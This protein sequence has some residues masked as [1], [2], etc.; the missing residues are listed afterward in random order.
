MKRLKNLAS[1]RTPFMEKHA[2][3]SLLKQPTEPKE[4]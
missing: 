1:V 2:E 3:L 4:L